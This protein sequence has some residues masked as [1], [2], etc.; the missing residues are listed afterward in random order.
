MINLHQSENKLLRHLENRWAMTNYN[1]SLK[2]DR[3]IYLEINSI[4]AFFFCNLTLLL[5]VCEKYQQR[6]RINIS[7]PLDF[8]VDLYNT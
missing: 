4:K 6:L 3:N 7:G 8:L 5:D 2:P 1:V